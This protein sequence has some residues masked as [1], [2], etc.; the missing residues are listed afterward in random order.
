MIPVSSQEGPEDSPALLVGR[1]VRGI[2]RP[3]TA[4]FFHFPF[5]LGKGSEVRMLSS[6]FE[7]LQKS[8]YSRTL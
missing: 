3:H 5:F 4:D 8:T 7:R 1:W 6:G 2:G